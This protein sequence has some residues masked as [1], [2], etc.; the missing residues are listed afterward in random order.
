MIPRITKVEYVKEHILNISFQDGVSGHIDLKDEL[1]GDIFAPLNDISYFKKFKLD[2]E[3]RT[4]V[5][6]NGADFAPEFLYEKLCVSSLLSRKNRLKKMHHWSSHMI[7]R[8]TKVEYVKEH[9]LNISFQD[10]VSGHIDLKDELDGDIFAPLNDISYFKKFKLDQE[11]RTI[12]W[13]N[14]A[15]F[16]PEFLYEKLCVSSTAPQSDY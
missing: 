12:V 4:I 15:D 9:I 11:L 3:L 8:I 13:P 5:W 2:Q 1:D 7:P 14:G 6:P 10:G 16:A